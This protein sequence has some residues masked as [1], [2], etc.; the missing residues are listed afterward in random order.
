MKNGSRFAALAVIMAIGCGAGAGDNPTAGES[1][2]TDGVQQPVK[3]KALTAPVTGTLDGANFTGVLEVTQFV[4]E[5][6]QIFAIGHLTNIAVDSAKHA[7]N[8]IAKL[9]HA[10]L[11]LPVG[12]EQPAT[13]EGTTDGNVASSS[14]A[15]APCDVL[16]LQLGPLD[17]DLLGLVVHLDQVTLNIDAQAGGGNLLGN[18]LCTITGL[19][20]PLAFLQNLA[21]IADL[22]N[23]VIALIGL[24]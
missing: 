15:L 24:L 22:L 20:D 14:A 21:Q 17:L 11:K 9:K 2:T 19:L 5:N 7:G 13:P 12:F 10:T 6:D 18:L 4:A 23:Q 16:F 1:Q 3:Q 8:D